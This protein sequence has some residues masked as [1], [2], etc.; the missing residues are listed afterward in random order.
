MTI[1]MVRGLLVEV[2]IKFVL[3]PEHVR[4]RDDTEQVGAQGTMLDQRGPVIV[5]AQ[6]HREVVG[7]GCSAASRRSAK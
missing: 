4:R 5:G 2:P 1:L 6:T 7:E 3:N